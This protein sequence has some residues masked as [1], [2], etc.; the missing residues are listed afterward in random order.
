MAD[1]SIKYLGLELKN[2]VIVGA[3]NLVLDHENVKKMEAAGAAAVV[4][5]S[6]FEEQ[7][8]LERLQLDEEL[9]EYKERNA[10]MTRLFPNLEHAG[11]TEHLE[12]IKRLKQT[13]NIPIIAS[14]NAVYEE[15]W[16][17]YALA[18]EDAGA[19]A[20][21]LNFYSAPDDFKKDEKNIINEQLDIIDIVKKKLKVPVSVKISPFYSNVLNVVQ[22]MYYEG[23]DGFVLFN[24]LFQPD[25]D[26]DKEEHHFPYHISHEDDNRLPLRFAGLLFGEIRGD[27]CSNTGIFNGK[28]VVKMLLAGA[29]CVQVV[30]TLYKNGIEQ[31]ST[32]LDELNTWMDTHQYQ[33]IDQFRGKLSK[34]SLKDPFVY[35]RAQYVDILM[36]S[37]E[38]F[39]K[40]PMI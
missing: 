19:D 7:I 6:L 18:L 24:R 5:K 36:K 40:Y 28:D 31:I 38:I 13:V 15:T 8:Q 11:S 22:R 10:E 21:E 3:S 29:T 12:N 20:I 2:P 14:L 25:I 39:K 32:I 34:K 30:S 1:L 9:A 16:E 27:L 17:E 35:K 23:A 33:T 4:Y 26:V 37:A